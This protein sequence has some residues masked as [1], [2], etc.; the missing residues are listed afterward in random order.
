MNAS[1]LGPLRSGRW[2]GA[3]LLAGLVAPTAAAAQ[4]V[5]PARAPLAASG[6]AA[7]PRHRPFFA[8]VEGGGSYMALLSVR[9]SHSVF[10]NLVTYTGWGPGFGATAG[11]HL[12]L[13]S[14]ALQLHASFF[15]GD[16]TVLNPSEGSG[17]TTRGTFHMI[18]TT[19]EGAFRLPMGRV[20]LTL[21][22]GVGHMFMGGFT[23]GAATTS[24][25]V[26]ADGWTLRTGVG[27]DV[28]FY[29]PWFV[30][31]DVD[32]AV[33]NVRRAGI[34]GTDCP[35][36]DPLCAELQQDGDAVALMLRPHLQVGL[37]F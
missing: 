32:A 16:G 25:N 26:T 23:S 37:H 29:G 15:G 13:F 33:A 18:A 30:G 4:H 21:R 20:E 11:V 19:L 35:G 10:P 31:L 5:A 14:V 27:V 24:S 6:T 8:E 34:A 7:A 12:L 17:T 3:L 22:V 28:R 2:A 9:G 1:T 36:T